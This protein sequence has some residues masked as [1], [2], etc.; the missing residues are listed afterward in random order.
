[1]AATNR[2]DMIDPALLRPGRL[3]RLVYV[4][5]P[6]LTS[7]R[8]IFEIGLRSMPTTSNINLN[9]LAEDAEGLSG[10]EVIG[11]CREAALGAIEENKDCVEQ[12]L[13]PSS[14]L[15]FVLFHLDNFITVTEYRI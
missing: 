5:P 11:V 14:S 7:R 3:D 10:A 13:S 12:V 1:M 15:T 6:D 2:P 8:R 9:M 4:P